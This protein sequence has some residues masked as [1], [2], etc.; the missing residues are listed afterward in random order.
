NPIIPCMPDPTLFRSLLLGPVQ[1]TVADEKEENANDDTRADLRPGG[2]E[3]FRPAP[4]E[5]NRPRGEVAHSGRVE[6][7]DGFNRIANS[8]IRAE[9]HT[10]E[11]QSPDHV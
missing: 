1:R 5:K 8:Q 7:W 6:R 10:S 11:L 4:E 3:A 2:A 9:E